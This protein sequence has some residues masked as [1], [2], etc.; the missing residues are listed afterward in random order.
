M[1]RVPLRF[2]AL[3]AALL[4]ASCSAAPRPA[5]ESPAVDA[6]P[7]PT[8][9]PRLESIQLTYPI[10]G[11]CCIPMVAAVHRK[12]FEQN[13]LDVD[14]M[15]MSNDRAMPAMA[16]GDLQYVGGVGTASVAASAQGLPVRAVWISATT[17]S[18]ML[19]ARPEIT[20]I[21]QL[22]DKRVAVAGLGNTGT[23]SFQIALKHYGIDPERD[24]VLAQFAAEE[25]RLEGLRSGAVDASLLSASALVAAATREGFRLLGD[26]GTFVQMP[27]GG[28]TVPLDTLAKN[29]DQVRRVIRALDQAQQWVLANRA[30]T[31]QLIVEEWRTDQATAEATYDEA[32]PAYQGK[33][34]VSREGIDNILQGLRDVGRISPDVRYEDVADGQL[35]EEVAQELGLL[36]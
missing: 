19:F 28:L 25:L 2:V 34:L 20:A 24:V 22:R 18:T 23:L 10:A 4:L 8:A 5:S 6:G 31:V 29:R 26:V 1:T 7:A 3:L 9:S 33:G 21:D 11:G 14:L 17:R 32:V 12:F 13:G 15:L 36:P 27:I 16:G 35:A 30:E